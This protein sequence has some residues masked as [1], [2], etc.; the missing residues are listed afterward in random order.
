MPAH[1]PTTGISLPSRFG[2]CRVQSIG[3]ALRTGDRRP[4]QVLTI[5]RLSL[6]IC[7]LPDALASACQME[8]RLCEHESGA[9][10]RLQVHA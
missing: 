5:P 8:E 7:R 9:K 4:R 2:I 10:Q 3:H 6:V 1:E